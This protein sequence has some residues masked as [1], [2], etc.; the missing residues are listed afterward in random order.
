ME[1]DKRILEVMRKFE[2]ASEPFASYDVP[3]EFRKYKAEHP[4]EKAA[5]A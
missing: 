3:A 4:E 5:V 2:E 1:T